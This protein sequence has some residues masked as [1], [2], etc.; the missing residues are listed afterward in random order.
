MA[1][2]AL[3]VIEKL[4]PDPN[5]GVQRIGAVQS[6]LAVKKTPSDNTPVFEITGELVEV[7]VNVPGTPTVKVTL[8][9]LV[10]CGVAEVC[11]K[12]AKPVVASSRI[13]RAEL[14]CTAQEN[15]I[16]IFIDPIKACQY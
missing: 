6:A 11:A 4:P 7:M 13:S 16:S 12:I 9:P 14:R 3:R 8:F 15:N 10:I 1:L 2:D 5:A